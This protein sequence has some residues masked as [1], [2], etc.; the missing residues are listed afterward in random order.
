MNIR[1]PIYEGV[2]RILTFVICFFFFVRTSFISESATGGSG[3]A[4]PATAGRR[5]TRVF[6]NPETYPCYYFAVIMTGFHYMSTDHD[7]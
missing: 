3:F 7:T 1:Y 6:G 5:E 4:L 2:Y